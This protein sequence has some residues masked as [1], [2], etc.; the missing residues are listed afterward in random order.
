MNKL[1]HFTKNLFLIIDIEKDRLCGFI[2]DHC[3]RMGSGH[4]PVFIPLVAVTTGLNNQI[5]ARLEF[6]IGR[7]IRSECQK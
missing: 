6:I 3:A 2:S 4:N 7:N 5:F 1:S